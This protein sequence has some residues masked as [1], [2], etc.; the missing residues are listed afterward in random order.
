MDLL[1]G[2]CLDLLPTLEDNSVDMVLTDLPYGRTN[3]TW[4]ILVPLEPLWAELLRVTKENAAI[5]LFGDGMF[6]ATLMMSKPSLWRYNLVWDRIHA[7]GFLNANRQPM[8]V[9]EDICVFYRKQP[10]YNSQKVPGSK[11]H[12]RGANAKQKVNSL[13][14]DFHAVDNT[15]EHGT[16]KHSTSIRSFQKPHPSVARHA[17]EKPVSL[18][19]WAVLSYTNPGDHVL[20]CTMGS[21]ST[22]RACENV[23]RKFTGM[24]NDLETYEGAVARLD[25]QQQRV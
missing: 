12:S 23:G 25:T 3:A 14:G 2:D 1:F 16:L 22:G 19:E 5:L 8:R 17:T 13:Y 18:L 24:E 20:D 11:S 4:D 7:S 10:T 9:H 15:E 6:T 21:G